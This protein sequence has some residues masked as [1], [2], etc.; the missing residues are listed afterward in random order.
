MTSC[1]MF[2]GRLWALVEFDRCRQVRHHESLSD[3]FYLPGFLCK[4]QVRSGKVFVA[5]AL[6]LL[7]P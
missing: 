3:S 6:S 1:A 2:L 7:Q 4:E 5:H